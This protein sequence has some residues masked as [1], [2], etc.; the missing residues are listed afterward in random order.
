M[1]KETIQERLHRL[2]NAGRKTPK[3]TV[4]PQID[5]FAHTRVKVKPKRVGGYLDSLLDEVDIKYRGK[6]R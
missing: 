6:V 4:E 5:V 3:P 1:A 2:A